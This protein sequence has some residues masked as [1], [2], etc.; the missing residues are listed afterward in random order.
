MISQSSLIKSTWYH[1]ILPSTHLKLRPRKVQEKLKSTKWDILR[2]HLDLEGCQ[3]VMKLLFWFRIEIFWNFPFLHA[4]SIACIH[5]NF[6]NTRKDSV[7]VQGKRNVFRRSIKNW[8][9]WWWW[10]WCWWWKQASQKMFKN[11]ENNVTKSQ[12]IIK[13]YDTLHEIMMI[14]ARFEYKKMFRNFVLSPVRGLEHV[15]S[16]VR[17]LEQIFRPPK[18]MFSARAKTPGTRIPVWNRQEQTGT[19]RTDR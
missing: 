16:P 10:W 5:R 17:G 19:D 12:N 13:K 8:R 4:A 3:N 2:Q 14:C 11:L 9:R 7:G 1:C 6:E 18:N 15:L